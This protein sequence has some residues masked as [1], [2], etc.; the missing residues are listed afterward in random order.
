MSTTLSIQD[1]PHKPSNIRSF[2]DELQRNLTASPTLKDLLT[3]NAHIGHE[4]FI[5]KVVGTV[6][7]NTTL[8]SCS[9][10][11]IME[12]CLKSA[13]LG[14][15]IDASGYAYLVP[16][17]KD[18][19]YQIGSKGYIELMKRNKNVRSVITETVYDGD[20]FD[21]YVDESG[22]HIKHIP[23]LDVETR[24]NEKGFKAVYAIVSYDNGG[25]EIEVMSKSTID[26]IKAVASTRS[27]WNIWYAEKA[28]TAVIK[29]L[30]KRASL[31]NIDTAIAMDDS[32]K[33]DIIIP[34]SI[35]N[36]VA[37]YEPSV[38][39]IASDNAIS[40]EIIDPENQNI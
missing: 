3:N 2:R 13:Q 27:I 32:E 20:V 35:D 39:N 31:M 26:K 22:K 1:L 23:N 36:L 19:T 7:G 18:A 34:P 6:M 29:R 37:D 28:K 5:A 21:Y 38:E 10:N 12:C 16:K 24:E 8:R 14:L 15:P 33:T 17:G 11:S 30:G 4:K 9:I 40:S 25:S